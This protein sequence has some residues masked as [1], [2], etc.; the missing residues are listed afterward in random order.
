[1][2]PEITHMKC[3]CWLFFVTRKGPLN[4]LIEM[5]RFIPDVEGLSDYLILGWSLLAFAEFERNDLLL[6]CQ[7]CLIWVKVGVGGREKEGVSEWKKEK[8]GPKHAACLHLC[9]WFRRDRLIFVFD[10][11]KSVI[12]MF[13]KEDCTLRGFITEHWK[14]KPT[15]EGRILCYV[16]SANSRKKKKII[17]FIFFETD[18]ASYFCTVSFFLHCS[19]ILHWVLCP[20]L[21][22]H[23]TSHL[24]LPFVLCNTLRLHTAIY[25]ASPLA[26]L[27]IS[28]PPSLSHPSSSLFVHRPIFVS[29]LYWSGSKCGRKLA[30]FRTSL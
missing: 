2:F 9:L 11:V 15:V 30:S 3:S 12:D 1:M 4:P 21:F 18:Q 8:N 27:F 5:S 10:A 16:R 7:I 17:S 6:C 14:K 26:G 19:F 23:P 20:R 13:H 28:F 22:L 24:S 29:L 25:S